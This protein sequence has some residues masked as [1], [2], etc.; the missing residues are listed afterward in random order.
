MMS[1]GFGADA[2]PD[3]IGVVMQGPVAALDRELHAVVTMTQEATQGHALVVVAGTGTWSGATRSAMTGPDLLRGV[4]QLTGLSTPPAQA[5]VPGGVFLDEAALIKE[6][7]TGQV[8]QKAFLDL[9]DTSGDAVMSDAFQAFA[10][11]FSRYC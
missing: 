1:D 5:A 11:S 3:L 6:H 7:V 4:D 2:T 9:R 10:V 8:V